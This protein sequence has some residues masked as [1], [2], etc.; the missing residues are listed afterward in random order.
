MSLP[1][2]RQRLN[3]DDYLKDKKEDS[4]KPF[5]ATVFAQRNAQ[6]CEQFSLITVGL[7]IVFFSKFCDVCITRSS[8]LVLGFVF[9]VFCIF[10][11]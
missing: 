5:C 4:S 3:D 10:R 6:T 1:F 7:G 2:I 11:D 9:S 8:L